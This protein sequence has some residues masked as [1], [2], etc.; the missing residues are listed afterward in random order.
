MAHYKRRRP[1]IAGTRKPSTPG[2]WRT[3]PR[4]WDIIRHTRR[5]RAEER[6]I[7]WRILAGHLDADDAAWPL[8]NHRPHNYYW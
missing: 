3:Y 1:R 7:A 5:R 8:G 4:W 2:H 6:H